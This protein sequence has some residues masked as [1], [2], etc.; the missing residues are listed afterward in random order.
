VHAD[1]RQRAVG[2]DRDDP[3]ADRI[4]VVDQVAL[5]R[6]Q[7]RDERAGE[8]G[9]PAFLEDRELEPLDV[10]VRGRPACADPALLDPELVESVGEFVGAKLG[11]DASMSVKGWL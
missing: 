2:Q 5:E 8:R 7:L 4:E 1:H 11:A 3:V 9:S 10:A 6:G